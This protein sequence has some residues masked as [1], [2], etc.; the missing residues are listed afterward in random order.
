MSNPGAAYSPFTDTPIYFE[1]IKRM[2]FLINTFAQSMEKPA[3]YRGINAKLSNL[4][5][6]GIIHMFNRKQYIGLI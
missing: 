4:A 5:G 6:R 1:L 2:A 3:V